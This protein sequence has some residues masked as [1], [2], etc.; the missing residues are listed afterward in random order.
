MSYN[1]VLS[2]E[3][4]YTGPFCR[5]FSLQRGVDGAACH[6]TVTYIR[7]SPRISCLGDGGGARGGK[8]VETSPLLA[9]LA[10]FLLHFWMSSR[11]V[12][13][14][15]LLSSMSPP[16]DKYRDVLCLVSNNAVKFL[17]SGHSPF[18]GKLE[19]GGN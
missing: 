1:W 9:L 16:E 19:E 18:S 2:V 17:R 12:P 7:P 8:S 6:L 11:L 15:T 13:F 4:V 10:D 3:E 14:I 5:C